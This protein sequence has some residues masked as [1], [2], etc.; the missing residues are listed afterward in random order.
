MG[1]KKEYNEKK[2]VNLIIR[3][4]YQLMRHSRSNVNFIVRMII[5]QT[6]FWF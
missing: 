6:R 4:N 3:F 5:I 2:P 1:S